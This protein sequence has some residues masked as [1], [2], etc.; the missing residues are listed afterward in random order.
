MGTAKAKNLVTTNPWDQ[1]LEEKR[2]R[3]ERSVNAPALRQRFPNLA[4]M[5]NLDNTLHFTSFEAFRTALED[6]YPQDERKQ[7]IIESL[8]PH[9]NQTQSLGQASIATTGCNLNARFFWGSLMTLI[10]VSPYNH[11][12]DQTWL[13]PLNSG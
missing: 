6:L 5:F 12:P 4:Q 1:M 11:I 7:M 13:L 3:L 10:C 8:L 9:F 2:N